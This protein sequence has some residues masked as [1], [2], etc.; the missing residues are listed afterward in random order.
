VS[1]R[2][3]RTVSSQRVLAAPLVGVAKHGRSCAHG[4]RSNL[5]RAGV[6]TLVSVGCGLPVAQGRA[7]LRYLHKA[8]L[9]ARRVV[10]ALVP[11]ILFEIGLADL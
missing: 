11:Y 10:A 7:G 9:F 1:Q 8:V 4:V 3:L 2:R 6:A 5:R